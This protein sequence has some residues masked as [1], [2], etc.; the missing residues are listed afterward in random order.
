MGSKLEQDCRPKV[1]VDGCGSKL[2][3]DCK[4]KVEVD[5]SSSSTFSLIEIKGLLLGIQ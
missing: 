3:V 1:E 2:E 5:G 4:L